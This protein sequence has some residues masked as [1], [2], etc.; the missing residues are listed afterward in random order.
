MS[1]MTAKDEQIS[2]KIAVN[3]KWKLSEGTDRR[4]RQ[5]EQTEGTDRR[6]RQKR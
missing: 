3:G 2:W 4:N 1:E 6:D 5:K